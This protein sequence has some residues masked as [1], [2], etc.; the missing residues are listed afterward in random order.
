MQHS[1]QV[2]A[3]RCA[4]LQ[5]LNVADL[6]AGAARAPASKVSC[7]LKGNPKNKPQR[8]LKKETFCEPFVDF[9]I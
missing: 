8:K 2:R 7:E 6:I 5:V 3:R 4:E 9:L 1:S